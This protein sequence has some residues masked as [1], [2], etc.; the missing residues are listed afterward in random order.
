MVA[1]LEY[2]T[3]WKSIFLV[4][5]RWSISSD[6]FSVSIAQKTRNC[7]LKVKVYPPE[8]VAEESL[9]RVSV[10][11]RE[12]FSTRVNVRA[13][14]PTDTSVSKITVPVSDDKG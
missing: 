12:G 4:L 11:L 3:K 14:V 1:D 13:G 2:L 8:V 7:I 5:E 6:F 10:V 9:H